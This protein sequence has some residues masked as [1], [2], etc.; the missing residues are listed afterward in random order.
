VP[1]P[2]SIDT[3][4]PRPAVG[5][6]AGT[7]ALVVLGLAAFAAAYGQAPLYYSNQ[8]QY[9]LH[10]LA[11]AGD[12]ALQE[13]WLAGT[14]DPTPAFS[15]MV[16]VTSRY[17][18]PWVFYVYH[19][20]L[21]SVYAAAM[22]GL[23]AWLA[24]PET[25]ARRWPI[26]LALLIAVHSAGV[27]WLSS[28]LF[29]LDYPWYF[30]AGV[31]GQYVLGG[32][33]QPSVFGVLLVLS[34]CLFVRGRPLWAAVAAA[35]GA[36]IHSTYVLPAGLLTAGY[37]TSLLFEREPRRAFVLGRLS[38][39]LVL[40][41]TAYTFVTFSPSSTTQFAE[42]SDI[43]VNLRIPHH[44]RPD[45]WLDPIAWLQIAWI[46][47][48]L[49]LTW[50]NRLLPV[51]AAPLALAAILTAVQVAT[52]S[53]TLALMFPWRISAV[54]VPIATAVVL[55]RLVAIPAVPLDGAPVRLCAAVAIALLAAAGVWICADGLAFRGGDEDL[56]L[57]EFVKGHCRPH[58]LYMV[59]VRVPGLARTTHGSLSGDFK[60]PADKMKDTRLIPVELQ[61]FRLGTGV[62][63][64]VDFKSIPYKDTEV[65]EWRYRIGR[66]QDWYAAIGQGESS[67]AVAEMRQWGITHVVVPAGKR[68]AVRGVAKLPFDDPHYQV[69]RIGG[70]VA[71][72]IPTNI[73][74]KLDE[75]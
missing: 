31:A 57:M 4:P 54:L 53:D 1:Q 49:A 37:L 2:S 62:P 44:C 63:I 36:S 6:R 47:A 20:V 22:L 73:Q 35:A 41:V 32:M 11:N 14:L 46:C 33:L 10:G 67:D 18:Q 13:D 50:R 8:N 24:G 5:V 60:P 70:G 68:L 23:F 9:F 12:G 51:L 39:G 74:L 19:G 34:V 30:Q 69:Y 58:D 59:P 16:S 40:P 52:G 48:A 15:A 21:L 3:T 28:H 29:G 43:L 75:Q 26:F 45:L 25:A 65:I 55:S 71:D 61:R 72:N 56:A 27:R 7:I 42:A 64:F 38:L 17:L 66:V